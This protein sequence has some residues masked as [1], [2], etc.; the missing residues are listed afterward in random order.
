MP[1]P[2]P[3]PAFSSR[4]EELEELI[5]ELRKQRHEAS[6]SLTNPNW[7]YEATK[8]FEDTLKGVDILLR[9][10]ESNLAALEE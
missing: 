7:D 5:A 2:T 1:Y 9:A 10:A 3:Q 4:R 6:M 8:R